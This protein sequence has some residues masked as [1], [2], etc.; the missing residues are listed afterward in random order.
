[1]PARVAPAAATASPTV[2][3]ERWARQ[4]FAHPDPQSWIDGLQPFTTQEYLGLLGTVDVAQLPSGEVAGGA[5]L[6]SQQA[7]SA[8]VTVPTSALTLRVETVRTPQGWR[9]AS[10]DR[11]S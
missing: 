5:Q 4:W 1:M 9:V 2:V 11:S 10:A 6:V 3:A 8:T 7:S